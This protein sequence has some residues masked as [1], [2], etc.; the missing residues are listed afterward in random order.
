MTSESS[1]DAVFTG[2]KSDSGTTNGSNFNNLVSV[3]SYNF[4]KKAYQKGMYSILIVTW[5]LLAMVAW[6][7]WLFLPMTFVACLYNPW[8]LP[9]SILC[10][11]LCLRSVNAVLTRKQKG[12]LIKSSTQKFTCCRLTARLRSTRFKINECRSSQCRDSQSS[13]D[14]NLVDEHREKDKKY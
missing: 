7:F 6:T 5:Y 8:A 10:S 13:N 4:L 3:H 2:S 9:C 14:E 11:I 1:L 12:P